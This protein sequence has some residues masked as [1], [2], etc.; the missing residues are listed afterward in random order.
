MQKHDCHG[1]AT[2]VRVSAQYRRH[3]HMKHIAFLKPANIQPDWERLDSFSGSRDRYT[4]HSPRYL[5]RSLFSGL[6]EQALNLHLQGMEGQRPKRIAILLGSKEYAN[7]SLLRELRKLSYRGA[8]KGS[9]KSSG[10]RWPYV[11]EPGR[12]HRVFPGACSGR[13]SVCSD[14]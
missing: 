11:L 7:S 13:A 8:T 4:T 14:C 9:N 5:K 2:S 6:G 3:V 12:I 10:P 1:C